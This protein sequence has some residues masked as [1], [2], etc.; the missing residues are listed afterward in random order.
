[1][2]KKS[3]VEAVIE[4]KLCQ[5]AAERDRL[6]A[7]ADA[8]RET[9][10]QLQETKAAPKRAKLSAARKATVEKFNEIAKG[11]AEGKP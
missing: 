1:M 10:R 4:A 7:V 8:L 5:V 9:L 11:A 2:A 3:K 6:D